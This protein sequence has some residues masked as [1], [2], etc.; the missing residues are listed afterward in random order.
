MKILS[1][2]RHS[3]SAK[4]LIL[5]IIT[6]MSISWLLGG[7]FRHT[8]GE[9]L[10]F[11][12]H[13]HMEQY[14]T[15]I[16]EDIGVPPNLIRAKAL[17]E[18]L[19]LNIYIYGPQIQWSSSNKNLD[20]ES[21]HFH[22]AKRHQ[23]WVAHRQNTFLLKTQN[24]GYK[25][26]F[27]MVNERAFR[28][29]SHMYI[30]AIL[31][32]LM[33][34]YVCY[35]IVKSLFSPLKSIQQGIQ[36]I[37]A[38][39]LSVRIRVTRNDEL[40]ELTQHINQMTDDIEKMLDAKR[41]LLLAISHELRTPITRTRVNLELIE[42]SNIKNNIQEDMVEMEQLINEL[43]EV[44]RLNSRHAKLQF[45]KI[46]INQLILTCV[47]AHF[48]EENIKLRL[49]T[50]TMTV[51]MDST[52][53]KFLIKNLLDNALRYSLNNQPVELLLS[54]ESGYLT[55]EIKD[56]GQ[57]IESQHIASLT[58]P[59]YRVDASRQ[60]KTGGYGLGLYLCRL[61]VEAHKGSLMIE[62]QVGKGTL[63][64]VRLPI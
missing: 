23:V 55:L 62:S 42:D 15:Y 37:G 52:R 40:G 36:K 38:G 35:R 64:Q 19:P 2:V 47:Q 13:P 17:S 39:D 61:I 32:I 27:E 59:F 10:R 31:L 54:S 3:L 22:P 58:E 7:S 24:A 50:Q 4:L 12:I 11:Y 34:L 16:H 28:K 43:L 60:R 20:L 26:I 41:Q 53:I 56:D 63:I 49:L 33:I 29:M 44:E 30:I 46:D 8:F 14:L 5:F 51:K 57:G 45:E 6:G 18:R 21:I 1:S 9:M 25:I 48:A